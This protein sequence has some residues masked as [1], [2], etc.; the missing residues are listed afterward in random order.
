MLWL[1]ETSTTEP[2]LALIDGCHARIVRQ[3]DTLEKLVAYWPAHGLDTAVQQAA[4]QIT[5]YFSKAAPD[6]H[7][8]EEQDLFPAIAA[9][10]PTTLLTQL[11]TEHRALEAAWAQL[12]PML[13]A[14]AHGK[15]PP[16]DRWLSWAQAFIVQNRNH[17]HCEDTHIVPLA[18]ARLSDVEL[19]QL[20]ARMIQRRREKPRVHQPSE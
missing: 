12:Q 13:I 15:M 9:W 4:A 3:C 6:H 17:Y 1:S 18:R 20:D 7:A 11:Y 16:D 5:R 19:A 10:V 14:L 8:D 2:P